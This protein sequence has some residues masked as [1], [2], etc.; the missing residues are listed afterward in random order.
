MNYINIRVQE[1]YGTACPCPNYGEVVV[2]MVQMVDNSY[3]PPTF[4][5]IITYG[6]PELSSGSWELTAALAREA[7]LNQICKNLSKFLNNRGLL[8]EYELFLE[9]EKVKREIFG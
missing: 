8:S 4:R 1:Y 6:T 3:S 5:T 7:E 9:T 2:N